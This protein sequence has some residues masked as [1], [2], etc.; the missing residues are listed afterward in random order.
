MFHWNRSRRAALAV[1]LLSMGLL[2]ACGG[3]SRSA[4]AQLTVMVPQA[5]SAADVARVQVE[6]S[7]P[8]IPAPL[9]TELV[10]VGGTWT[11]TISGIP[12]GTGRLFRA[13]AYDAAAKLLYRGEAGPLSIEPGKTA[14]VAIL[15]QQVEPQ[16][17]FENEAPRIDSL[18]VSTNP[19]EP[20]GSVTL[21]ASAHD[22]NPG[23]TLSYS[24]S[25]TAGTFSATGSAVTTWTAPSTEGSQRI[26]LEVVDSRGASATL[27]VDIGVLLPG[28]TGSATV[29][30]SF[31]TWPSITA[32]NGVPSVLLPGG[33]ARLMA[34]VTDAD[35]DVPLFSWESSCTGSFDDATRASPTFTLTALPGNGRCS[36]RLT[37][38]DGRGGQ[39][40]GT[41]I[42][43]AGT[44]PP[45]DV[46]PKIDASW[47]SVPGASGGAKV[48]LG[49]TAHDPE[50]TAL[51]FS[52]SASQGDFPWTPRQT[53][54][55]SEIDWR[56]P[57]CLS[58][59]VTVTVT[60]QDA[61]GSSASQLFSL[62]PAPNSECTPA[63]VTGMRNALRVQADGSVLPSPFGLTN[64]A[65]GAWVPTSDGLS[66]SWRAGTGHAHG[67]FVIPEVTE[68]SPYLLRY[69]NSYIW[70]R[71]RSLELD[72]VEL[73]HRQVRV[74]GPPEANLEMEL[75]GFSPWQV[76]DDLQFHSETA[77]LG[78]LSTFGCIGPVFP[79]PAVG[80]TDLSGAVPYS[81]FAEQCGLSAYW[82]DQTEDHLF[83][84]QLV[85]RPDP[86]TGANVQEARRSILFSG[87]ENTAQGN[88]LL[89]GQL[90]PLPTTTQSLT[91]RAPEFE[92]LAQAGHPAATVRDN[93][94]GISTLL[95]YD[96]YG[97][98]T[99]APDV[100]T[101]YSML[102]GRGDIQ[103]VFEF[104]NPYPS[105]WPLFSFFQVTAE[106]PFTIELPEGGTAQPSYP[107][108]TAAR[109]PLVPGSNPTIV[110]KLGPARELRLNGL[111]ATENLTGVGTTPLLSW[112]VPALGTP[113]YYQLRL[114]RVS[115]MADG[116]VSRQSM[117]TLYTPETQLRLPPG[118]LATDRHYYVQVTA[119][120][121]PGVDPSN[122][123]KDSP[124][125]HYAPAV[126]GVFKP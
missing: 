81:W 79:L 33:S 99:T 103:P 64:V 86:R 69:A 16:V 59:P 30:A 50:G 67:T 65:L 35:G 4:S 85:S 112:T 9:L 119:Y 77:G 82:L 57:A 122:P 70:T 120:L 94:F 8:G 118:M 56:A 96:R 43:H 88:I 101:A 17:P 109:E 3:D 80:G 60:V 27:S 10:Q 38:T 87:P 21:T 61:A 29:N 113:T 47:Q 32:M 12:A 55:S 46:A 18:V 62:A 7:G 39:H 15:L 107:M 48:A 2:V 36:F 1:A 117:A 58:G 114:Y 34:T 41:L 63:M 31:N 91:I 73:G 22:A 108:Y 23:D 14:S 25:A 75:Q 111:V 115:V 93:N 45:P 20:G 37:A 54:T 76:G 105:H 83:V 100:A 123:F 19:V 124:V 78:Y 74:V 72:Q 126:T 97:G 106:V 89:R 28:S 68:G 95:A 51:S 121:R 52:W 6:L 44:T 26:Q 24:W 110:P 5:L 125:S 90:A 104:G 116:S 49:V 92:S 102:P 40:S 66:Y 11:G 71:G 13:S 53:A 98:Y 42:L 84:T